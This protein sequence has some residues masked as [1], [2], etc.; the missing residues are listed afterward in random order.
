MLL[1][2]ELLIDNFTF[3]LYSLPTA[4]YELPVGNRKVG[5]SSISKGKQCLAPPDPRTG[6]FHSSHRS[7]VN[8]QNLE[9]VTGVGK[10]QS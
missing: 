10:T 1:N 3:R 9:R 5:M 4:R 6:A 7:N 2:K 8:S